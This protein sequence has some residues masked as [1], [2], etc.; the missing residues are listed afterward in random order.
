M[1]AVI[2]FAGF[3]RRLE[4]VL[5]RWQRASSKGRKSARRVV[6]FVEIEFDFIGFG[7]WSVEES[8]RPVGGFSAR[9]VFKHE[10]ELAI[11]GDWFE[12]HR[13]PIDGELRVPRGRLLVCHAQDVGDGDLLRLRIRD[14]FGFHA[15]SGVGGEPFA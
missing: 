11:F 2:L 5:L 15:P 7:Y 10:E 13:L 1:M 9:R 6:G 3:D 4:Y 12:A 8:A 14:P